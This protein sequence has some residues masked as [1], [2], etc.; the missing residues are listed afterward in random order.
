M[1]PRYVIS[2][3]CTLLVFSAIGS[4]LRFATRSQVRA[5]TS[6]RET[7]QADF[8]LDTYAGSDRFY[9]VDDDIKTAL[10]NGITFAG[11]GPICIVSTKVQITP[12]DVTWEENK[13]HCTA[14]GAGMIAH[15]TWETRADAPDGAGGSIH[16]EFPR[17]RGLKGYIPDFRNG[18]F[19][20]TPSGQWVF[21]EITAY[22]TSASLALG[23]LGLAVA[24]ALPLT[25]V[26]EAARSLI[27]LNWR[28]RGRLKSLASHA[29]SELPRIF[30]PSPVAE[31]NSW[32]L[33]L[34]IFGFVGCILAG[35][36]VSEGFMSTRFWWAIVIMQF[37]GV[38]IALLV[39]Y[40]ARIAGVSVRVDDDT[41]SHAKGRGEPRWVTARWADLRGIVKKSQTYRGSRR[42]WLEVEFPDGKK[43]VIRDA[44]A[45]EAVLSL[46]AQF[47]RPA[48]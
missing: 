12:R 16:I 14:T 28:K 27:V 4:T 47:H 21:R 39:T 19:Q 29:S 38:L 46:Y 22:R 31:W 2:F 26:F 25:I 11:S 41:I 48:N 35:M 9:R 6:M 8:T 32:N 30:L 20:K 5:G 43:R 13:T 1:I 36:S 37:C 24:A 44:K 40:C 7:W 23:R 10:E 42:E 45:R 15:V 3:L 17:I 18:S 33:T 34:L